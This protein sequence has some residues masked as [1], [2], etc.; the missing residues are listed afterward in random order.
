LQPGC[1]QVAYCR[2]EQ[3]APKRPERGG[4]PPFGGQGLFV[5]VKKW[6]YTFNTNEIFVITLRRGR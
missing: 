3:N 1:G 2:A 4:M 6:L 5:G